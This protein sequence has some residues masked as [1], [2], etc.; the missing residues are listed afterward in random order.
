VNGRKPSFED[1]FITAQERNVRRGEINI[2]YKKY[3]KGGVGG[4]EELVESSVNGRKP[5][6]E[7]F[8]SLHKK[9]M[10]ARGKL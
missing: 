5:S 2:K 1:F 7:D 10:E 9:G 6:F 4:K 3:I 8:L